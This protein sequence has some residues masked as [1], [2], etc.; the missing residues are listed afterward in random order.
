R[1]LVDAHQQMLRETQFHLEIGD[2]LQERGLVEASVEPADVVAH[3][4]MAVERSVAVGQQPRHRT[5][6]RLLKRRPVRR[7][8]PAA[9]APPAGGA[10]PEQLFTASRALL[11]FEACSRQ[12]GS[13]LSERRLHAP[14]PGLMLPRRLIHRLIDPAIVLAPPVTEKILVRAFA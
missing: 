1:Q 13:G 9:V 10:A 2:L 7:E 3:H 8:F 12:R 6:D 5:I 11:Y 14:P 4:G